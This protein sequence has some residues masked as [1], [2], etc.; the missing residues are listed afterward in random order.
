LTVFIS[1]LTKESGIALKDLDAIIVS[2]GPGSYTGLRIGVSI[3]KGLAYSLDLP[4]ISVN[5]L[6]AL[7]LLVVQKEL[8][9]SEAYYCPMIDARRMEVYWGLYDQNLNMIRE[10]AASVIDQNFIK[11]FPTDKP[12]YFFG[13]GMDKAKEKLSEMAGATFVENIQPSSTALAYLGFM[14]FK[15][16][17]FENV[18]SFE[19]F[20]LKDF[21]TTAKIME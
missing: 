14:K 5:T 1:E 12:I 18:A 4:L 13:N 6:E 20:Y 16:K 10:T 21:F 7:A 11:Q 3:A 15:T 19:P 2:K 9:Q 17:H 8:M